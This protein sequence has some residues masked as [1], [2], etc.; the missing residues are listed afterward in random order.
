[1]IPLAISFTD[2]RAERKDSR[3]NTEQLKGL[4]NVLAGK[5]V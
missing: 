2:I 1:M 4:E 3:K 5:L